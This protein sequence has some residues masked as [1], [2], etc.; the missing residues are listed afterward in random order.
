MFAH[1][2]FRSGQVGNFGN[3]LLEAQIL[4]YLMKMKI[5]YSSLKYNI[6]YLFHNKLY[7][8][9]VTYDM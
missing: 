9:N 2:I 7:I 4:N 3:K 1:G 6:F 5:S 8:S